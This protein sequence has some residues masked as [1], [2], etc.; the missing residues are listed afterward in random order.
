MIFNKTKNKIKELEEEIYNLKQENICLKNVTKLN[1]FYSD[2]CL[3]ISNTNKYLEALQDINDFYKMNNFDEN[4]VSNEKIHKYIVGKKG[5][6][7]ILNEIKKYKK[8]GKNLGY[9]YDFNIQDEN[10]RTQIDFLIISTNSIYIIEVKNLNTKELHLCKGNEKYYIKPI[11]NKEYDD[12]DDKIKNI[13]FDKIIER[14]KLISNIKNK[15]KTEYGYAPTNIFNLLVFINNNE[16]LSIDN[17]DEV[18]NDKVNCIE[19]PLYNNKKLQVVLGVENLNSYFKKF[20]GSI[21]NAHNEQDLK[22]DN[23]IKFIKSDITFKN[24]SDKNYIIKE[25]NNFFDDVY[26][27][28]DCEKRPLIFKL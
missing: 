10:Y 23:F 18:S 19:I 1:K 5:E 17:F 15:F 13:L 11:Y 6:I 14:N 9:I 4:V 26:K 24:S 28:A 7:L 21:H 8:I 25:I 27:W 16:L 12:K 20:L 3:K 22:V 2:I